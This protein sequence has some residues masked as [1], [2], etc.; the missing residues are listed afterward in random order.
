MLL[1]IGAGIIFAILIAHWF[2]LSLSVKLILLGIG[3]ALLPDIDAPV[4]L[5][6]RGRLGGKTEGV[7]RELSHYPLVYIPLI[8][9]VWYFFG[10]AYGILFLLG[11]LFHFLHDSTGIGWG[12]KWWA[13]F[14]QRKHKFFSNKDGSFSWSHLFVSWEPKELQSTVAEHG[15][16]NWFRD[17]YLR[18][19][20]TSIVELG[21]FIIALIVLYFTLHQH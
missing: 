16:D 3:F 13:P 15:N 5:F 6:M 12:I 17:I 10:I 7:H 2:G 4:E 19:S 11:V 9:G 14:S 20:L 8:A 1:D 21:G 18:P